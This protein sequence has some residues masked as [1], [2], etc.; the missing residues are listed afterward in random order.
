MKIQ[1]KIIPRKQGCILTHLSQLLWCRLKLKLIFSSHSPA[2]CLLLFPV[3]FPGLF[4][5]YSGE[6]VE[7][8]ISSGTSGS[9]QWSSFSVPP[10]WR[11]FSSSIITLPLRSSLCLLLCSHQPVLLSLVH[12]IP[13]HRQAD[14][15]LKLILCESCCPRWWCCCVGLTVRQLVDCS[16]SSALNR[17]LPETLVYPTLILN[18]LLAA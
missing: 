5:V 7:S 17:P 1:L 3:S 10:P 9:S 12:I 8:V 11:S 4:A 16:A 14:D 13:L 18:S 2:H 6:S 15:T